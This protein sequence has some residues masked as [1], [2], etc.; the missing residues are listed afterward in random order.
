[1][2][3]MWYISHQLLNINNLIKLKFSKAS[4]VF[5]TNTKSQ[6]KVYEFKNN[7]SNI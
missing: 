6:Y 3:K 2:L 7:I 4:T 1:M 5:N